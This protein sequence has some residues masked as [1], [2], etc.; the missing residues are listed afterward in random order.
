M[1]A[2]IE[3]AGVEAPA[4]SL[5]RDDVHHRLGTLTRS[6]HDALRELGYDKAVHDAAVALPDA[7]A[8]LNYITKLTGDAAERVLGA[9]E[10]AQSGQQALRDAAAQLAARW[11]DAD[12]GTIA[13]RDLVALAGD[14]RDFIRSMPAR[15][16]ECS[17]ELTE[18][19]LAQEFHDLTGQMIDRI[20][21]VA[22][23]MEEHL[24]KLLLET[25]PPERLAEVQPGVLEGPVFNAAGRKDV[26]TDQRQVDD[27][28]AS[29][30]F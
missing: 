25:T 22:V 20:G 23:A 18:I 3:A 24:V 9:V 10:R 12:E 19:M 2:M 27:L 29:L 6:L 16:D 14:S 8:R 30:G 15:Y 4:M 7:R 21:K 1:G 17:R 11:N 5:S 28:L 26:V 13:V